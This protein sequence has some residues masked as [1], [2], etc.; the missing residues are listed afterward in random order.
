MNTVEKIGRQT[1]C[2][3]TI[4]SRDFRDALSKTATAVTVVATSGPYGLAGL[5]CSAVCSVCDQ[6]STI[7]LCVNRKSYAA[8]I[9]KSNGVLSVN[10]LASDQA[11]VS[12]IFAGV[13]SLPMEE[14]FETDGWQALVTGAP[15]RTDAL[16]SFDCTIVNTVDVGSH[17][18]IFAE[19]VAE[20]RSEKRLPLIY[21]RRTYA[22]TQSLM[23]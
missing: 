10:W 5:T 20:T 11:T 3:E 8:D 23:D 9:I 16:V 19:V 2:S 13:G 22:T 12:Q 6:P 18:V 1:E 21:H 7:L 14:R 15:C 17:M 4:A